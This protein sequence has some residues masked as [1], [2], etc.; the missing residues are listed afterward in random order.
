MRTNCRTAPTLQRVSDIRVHTAF[1]ILYQGKILYMT[2]FFLFNRFGF[3]DNCP[4]VCDS[5][6]QQQEMNIL[7]SGS[8]EMTTE[9][10]VGDT[11]AIYLTLQAV[12][13]EEELQS[14]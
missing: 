5:T 1:F 9:I 11:T 3:R 2:S 13:S 8:S 12:K 14:M 7:R 10:D 4:V 6:A